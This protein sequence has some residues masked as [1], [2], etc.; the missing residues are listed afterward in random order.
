MKQIFRKIHKKLY[1]VKTNIIRKRKISFKNKFIS[2]DYGESRGTPINRF[3]AQHF[4]SNLGKINFGNCLEFGDTRYIDQFGNNVKKKVIF[5]YSKIFQKQKNII[6]GN[7][8]ERDQLPEEEFDLIVCAFVLN[9]IFDTKL[10]IDNLF[11][12]LKPNGRCI[13]ILDGPLSQISN[14]D[15]KR[16]GDFWRFTDKSAKLA[17]KNGKFK[18]EKENIYGNPYSST[19]QLNGYCINEVDTN[20]LFPNHED[21]QLLLTYSLIKS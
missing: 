13:V 15:M 17:F 8:T 10:A 3:Y 1:R 14:Y 6:N 2:N 11:Y 19:A 4:F 5:N 16:W 12:M 9:F 18:I 21:Y 20:K 7:L